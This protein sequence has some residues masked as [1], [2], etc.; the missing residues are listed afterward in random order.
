[1]NFASD[2]INFAFLNGLKY[3]QGKKQTTF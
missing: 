1:M 2:Y 3:I